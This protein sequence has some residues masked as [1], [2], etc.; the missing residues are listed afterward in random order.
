MARKSYLVFWHLISRLIGLT[1]ALAAAIGLVLWL[2]ADEEIGRQIAL[3]G[4]AAVALALLVE[5]AALVRL[6][7]SRRGAVGSNVL[8]QVVLATLILGGVNVFSFLHYQRFDWTSKR[9]FTLDEKLRAELS[10]LSGEEPT[11]IVVYRRQTSIGP[12][13]KADPYAVAAD[14]KIIEKVRDL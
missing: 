8:L 13:G 4:G 3:G 9:E 10:K 2:V 5:L 12:Q 11:T 1:G 14:K 7:T 6:A